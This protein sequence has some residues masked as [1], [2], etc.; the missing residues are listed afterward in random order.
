MN[1][2]T[3]YHTLNCNE[4]NI[5]IN[6]VKN[7]LIINNIEI[8]QIINLLNNTS[9]NGVEDFINNIEEI[10]WFEINEKSLF[11]INSLDPVIINN[12][13]INTNFSSIFC[14]LS[15]NYYL[16][17]TN[18]PSNILPYT[19]VVSTNYKDVYNN[20]PLEYSSIYY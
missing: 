14:R 19:I 1:I 12:P 7:T 4:I 9:Q 6:K 20:I 11:Y 15:N 2:P 5:V 3:K 13:I 16:F 8:P 10:F 17:Y 18:M